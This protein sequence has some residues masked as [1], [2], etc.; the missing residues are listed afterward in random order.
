MADFS[1]EGR[2]LE[3]MSFARRYH[4]WIL[5]IFRP[6][7]GKVVAEVGAGS[8]DFSELLLE[9][10]IDRLVA[11]EPSG[12]MYGLLKQR[13][14]PDPRAQCV[15]DFFLNISD[16]YE[17]RFDSIVYVNVLEHIEHDREELRGAYRA[18]RPGGSICIFVPAL[19]FLYSAHDAS[20][21][22]FRRYHKRQLASLVESA[23]FAVVRARYFDIAGILPWLIFMK[24]LRSEPD[25][26]KVKL[27]D[28]FVVPVM[29]AAETLCPPPMGK[30]IVLIAQKPR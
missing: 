14:G 7:L 25:T 21:G 24:Y 8:G 11:V 4:L 12:K 30:N 10:S 6:F 16:Q 29:R 28:R 13:I 22:H 18:L 20:I 23:G 26:V 5:S 17:G 9:E 3:A 2:D 19:S 1:Y 15:N 27:Y